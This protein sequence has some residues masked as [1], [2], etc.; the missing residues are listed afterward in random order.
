MKLFEEIC[1]YKSLLSAFDR[2]EENGG[3]HG[4]DNVPIEEFSVNL[5]ERLL[6]LQRELLEGSYSPFPLRKISI[7]KPNGNIRW[8]SIPTVKDRI[9]QTSAAMILSP[10]LIKSLKIAVLLTGKTCRFKR[11]YIE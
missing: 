1:S 10:F 3:T 8:L 4:A 6:K 5:E 2:V 9:A 11:Q 7:T